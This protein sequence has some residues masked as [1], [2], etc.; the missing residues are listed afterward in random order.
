MNENENEN[1]LLDILGSIKLPED[2]LEKKIANFSTKKM[3]TVKFSIF[4][5][6]KKRID[7]VSEIENKIS[8]TPIISKIKIDSKFLRQFISTFIFWIKYITTS[9]FIF[10]VLLI[11]TNY[12]AYSNIIQSYIFEDSHR[13]TAISLLNS[14]DAWEIL[15]K[16]IIPTHKKSKKEKNEELKAIS[17]KTENITNAFSIK[18]IVTSNS[19]DDVDLS[20]NIVPYD[21]RLVIP[22]IGKNIPLIDIVEK[23]VESENKLD[24]ILMKELEFGV[25]RYPWSAKPGK[26]W[27]SFIFWHSS[28]FPWIAGNYNDVFARLWQME[29]W[30][31]VFS[32]YNQK[33]YKYRITTK[34]VVNPNDVWVLKNDESKKQLTLMTCW[35]IWT[36]LNRLILTAELIEE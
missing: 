5:K 29:K 9:V 8:N 3:I 30:D 4:I 19:K 14:V 26:K 13:Q 25:V 34:K 12:Q 24:N 36:T 32:Y 11:S 28:N 22:K 18:Q 7:N 21:N 31:I 6:F 10:W 17:L 35:P 2:I 16:G 27:N 23:T 1:E 33:K 20:I 15:E